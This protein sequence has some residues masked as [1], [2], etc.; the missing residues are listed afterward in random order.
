V[1]ICDDE[2]DIRLLYRLAM[3]AAGAIV[4]EAADGHE[5]VRIA[6]DVKPDLVLLDLVLPGLSGL[7]VL[8]ELRHRHPSIHVVVMS[9]LMSGTQ[10]DRSRELGADESLEKVGMVA[11][12]P[13]LVARYG[14][15][16]PTPGDA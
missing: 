15:R 4:V 5:C 6:H 13:A 2:P 8:T 10:A 3:E 16:S 12:I 14:P 7:E 9:G 1:L 11:R